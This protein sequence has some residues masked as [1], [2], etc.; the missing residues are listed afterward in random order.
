[1]NRLKSRYLV[2]L[3]WLLIIASSSCKKDSDT[4]TTKDS[5]S[6]GSMKDQEGT[7]YKT[8]TIGK[9]TWMAENLKTALYKVS[10]V[11]HKVT[12]MSKW[13]HNNPAY[14]NYN[15]SDSIGAIYGKLYNW[16]A[17]NTGKLCP[18]GWHVP[19]DANW[20]TLVVYLTKNGYTYE[21]NSVSV[22]MAM[23]ST[24]GWAYSSTEGNVGYSLT[25]N[26]KS[27]FTALPGGFVN[28]DGAF[29][30]LGQSAYFWS[31]TEID[32][33]KASNNFLVYNHSYPSETSVNKHTG[34]SVRCLKD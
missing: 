33:L 11:I 30:S 15:N 9:Q 14:C 24:V 25:S 23:A 18:N 3:F 19:T 26:N 5:I 7:E 17:V 4:A 21:S 1:M 20:D 32:S 22:A 6:V 12:E 31:S 29:Y 13:G 28:A 16:Y 2:I 27:K 8:V 34:F 10:A